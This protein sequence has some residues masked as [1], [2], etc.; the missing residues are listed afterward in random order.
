MTESPNQRLFWTGDGGAT[1]QERQILAEPY[2]YMVCNVRFLTPTLGLALVWE[3]TPGVY[4]SEDSGRTWKRQVYAPHRMIQDR[5]AGPGWLEFADLLH[6]LSIE[7]EGMLFTRD[8]GKTWQ[9]SRYCSNVN[10]K[11]LHQAPIGSPTWSGIAAQL[12]DAEYG[13][14]A[15]VGDLFR[16]T[17][18]GATWC[19][20]PPIRLGTREIN[21]AELHFANRKLGWAMP[22]MFGIGKLPIFETRDGGQSWK[23]VELPGDPWIYGMSVV[24]ES[25]IF[26]WDDTRLYRMI[27]N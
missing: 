11:V 6:G 27:P 23:P 9:N 4:R 5:R 14:W 25:V 16:T 13:W 20:L 18:G 22:D 15:M 8:G 3:R 2:S 1:W 7:H 26:V 19:Q 17:D 24:S 21:V 10:T 12:L